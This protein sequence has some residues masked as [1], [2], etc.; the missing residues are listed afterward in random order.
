MKMNTLKKLSLACA[1]VLVAGSLNAQT[2]A[3]SAV[4]TQ[5]PRAD[6][7]S[8]IG[9]T[10]SNPDNALGGLG[11]HDVNIGE[12]ANNSSSVEFVSLG[13]G[14]ILV[15]TFNDPIC[16]IPGENDLRVYETSYGTPSC[17]AW[18]ERALVWASQSN[19]GEASWV[20][21]S[22]EDGICQDADLDLGVLSWAKYIRIMD[23]TDATLN[24]FTAPNQD[25][26]DVDAVIGFQTCDGGSFDVG[27][28]YAVNGV[29]G[30][31]TLTQG[32]RR[33]G[34]AVPANRSIVSRMFGLP[35]ATGDNATPAAN[36]PFYALGY[37][38][39]VTLSFPYTILNGPGADL[40]VF[41]T[42]F[43]DNPTRTCASYPEKAS[44][45]GSANGVDWFDLEAVATADD[46]GLI[47]CRDGELMI[48][49]GQPGI[50]YI[51]VTDV[52]VPFGAQSTDAYD[53]DAIVGLG[54]CDNGSSSNGGKFGIAP[55]TGETIGEAEYGI[56]VY[57]NPTSGN[58]SITIEALNNKDNYTINVVDV[59]GRVISSEVINQGKASFIHNLDV[60]DL[61][62]GIY[63]IS[64]ESHNTREVTKLIKK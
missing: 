49:A 62:A 8:P 5:G 56:E 34:S 28:E 43:G 20:M 64:V 14:G 41:E 32:A 12:Q 18:P 3:S 44:F 40:A 48:P 13:F 42:T 26:F 1:T 59:M 52:T 22:P 47:L 15:L 45:E 35:A 29:V 37:G 46:G 57:P 50:N 38:G 24:V 10:R 60:Q 17:N 54:Q 6:G 31:P 53:I 33:N 25:G 16:N 4:Y 51:R 27:A 63:M 39:T 21:I 11:S 55:S 58:A 36:Y 19:C 2:T 30:D 61:P 7:V 9:L 23:I